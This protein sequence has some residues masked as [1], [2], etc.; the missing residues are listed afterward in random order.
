MPSFRLNV[1]HTRQ[2]DKDEDCY[3]VGMQYLDA[4]PKSV[5]VYATLYGSLVGW[6]LRAPGVAWRLENGLKQGVITTFCIDTQQ[7]WLALG[8]S[9]GFHIA[10]DLRFQL[11]IASI[12]HPSGKLGNLFHN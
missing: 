6:D 7:N 12:E 2:L 3:A 1:L 10:W 8:T 4:G 11:P 9:S 5:V